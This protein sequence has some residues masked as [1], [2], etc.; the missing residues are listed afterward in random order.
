MTRKKIIE[1]LSIILILLMLFLFSQQATIIHETLGNDSSC[2]IGL[3][4]SIIEN[5]AY[6]FNGEK[7]VIYPP[8]FP[9]LLAAISTVFS[10]DWYVFIKFNSV[11]GYLGVFL[12]FLLFRR[13]GFYFSLC[14]TLTI[15][16]SS[17]F[18]RL[19]T[20][21]V[22][23]DI[24]LFFVLML[25][26]YISNLTDSKDTSS[27]RLPILVLFSATLLSISILIRTAAVALVFAILVWLLFSR[28]KEK[29][30]LS[31]RMIPWCIILVV[32]ILVLSSWLYYVSTNKIEHYTGDQ[33]SSYVDQLL[34]KDP[35]NPWWGRAGPSDI[36]AR[37]LKL[38]CWNLSYLSRMILHLEWVQPVPYC[39]PIVLFSSLLLIG[40]LKTVF[41][42][43]ELYAWFTICYFGMILCF[44]FNEGERFVLPVMPFA[45]YYIWIGFN[46]IKEIFLERRK[47][48]LCFI[49][50]FFIIMALSTII[51]TYH[52]R[53][54][55]TLFRYSNF[56][57]W[58][59]AALLT[60]GVLFSFHL[61]R[62]FSTML[63][64]PVLT[65]VLGILL[66]ATTLLGIYNQYAIFMHNRNVDPTERR[67]HRSYQA[68]LEIRR[69]SNEDDVIMSS[70]VFMIHR[71]SGRRV[72]PLP[73][74]PDPEIII[75]TIKKYDVSYLVIFEPFKHE[76]MYPSERERL[77]RVLKA[78]ARLLALILRRSP[79]KQFRI[80]KITR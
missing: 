37:I 6:V 69:I 75:D 22:N 70:S 45:F 20:A 10:D 18:F 68:A 71:F 50:I 16:L 61:H 63:R 25:F 11:L 51:V 67:H 58:M 17:G 43:N 29:F 46:E 28:V 3:A 27:R 41:K 59:M 12:V 80:F 36:A 32:G 30:R 53:F 35:H 34:A 73:V 79:D 57:F 23:S 76:Y 62:L 48:C 42:S 60:L 74:T 19:N 52:L 24:P 15:A 47:L 2:Y 55:S 1:S 56:V 78:Q 77:S 9:L 39:V 21:L 33:M 64:P 26:F 72:I 66:T 4:R 49:S 13:F 54:A 14:C 5:H 8:G 31:L 38:F 7:H 65:A 40:L 44:P